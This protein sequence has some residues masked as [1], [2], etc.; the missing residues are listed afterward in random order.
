[1]IAWNLQ[2]VGSHAYI[3]IAVVFSAA[4]KTERATKKYVAAGIHIATGDLRAKY[5]ERAVE[6]RR[7]GTLDQ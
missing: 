2:N 1:M 7:P 6:T 5:S 4:E 3:Y